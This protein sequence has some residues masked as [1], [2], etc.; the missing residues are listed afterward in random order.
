MLY[1]IKNNYIF[2]IITIFIISRTLYYSLGIRFEGEPHYWQILPI[3]LLKTDLLNSLFYNFSQPPFLNFIYGIAIKITNTLPETVY[4][5]G[6]NYLYVLHFTYLFFGIISFLHFFDISQ[7]FLSKNNAFFL[8]SFLMIM[9]LTILWENHG[10]KDYL[11]M[12]FLVS[13]INYSLCI[14]KN[15]SFKNYFLLGVYLTFLCLL[16]ETFHLFWAYLFVFFEYFCNRR[17][18]KTVLL[19]LMITF[20]V[21]PFYL[22]NLLIF[23]KFQIAGW[24]YENLTQKTLFIT[25]MESG[26]HKKLKIFI[27]DNDKNYNKFID[28]LSPIKGNIFQS[29]HENYIKKLNYK[30]KYNHPLLHTDTFHN[31][32]MLEVDE[33]RKKDFFIYLKEYPEIF[34]VS[35]LNALTRH[36]FNSSE[37]FLFF[38]ENVEQIP[39]LVRFSHCLKITFLCFGKQKLPEYALMN[40][41]EKIIFSLEQ[42]NFLILFIYFFAFY[43]FFKFFFNKNNN[44]KHD[45]T[46]KFWTLSIIFML[47]L[48]LLFE[49]T[50]IPRHRFPYEY[51]VFL[52]SLYFYKK[53]RINKYLKTNR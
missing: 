25:E 44:N 23:N 36:Y 26:K 53:N 5:G 42:I 19:F 11:T 15:N 9:P 48:L 45:N 6:G 14:I 29:T 17:I 50:E 22:K 20:F 24:M 28:K 47:S 12:C 18:K 46:Y 10:Y 40:Y 34:L 33:I 43:Q 38:H 7:S 13:S 49:D 41:K 35:I 4:Q 32:V 31:E 37:N 52:L 3:D 2:L 39:I 30:Y 21:L 27:F 16:R 51:I 8:I 1:K